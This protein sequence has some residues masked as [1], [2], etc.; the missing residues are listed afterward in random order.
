M[1]RHVYELGSATVIV[2]HPGVGN[3]LDGI[4][5][6][7]FQTEVHPVD[8]SAPVQ[9]SVFAFFAWDAANRALKQYNETRSP[10]IWK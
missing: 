5:P 1:N 2:K 8:G 4:V 6:A 9:L 10:S 3:C 7:L